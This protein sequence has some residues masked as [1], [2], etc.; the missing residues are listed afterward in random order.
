MV[1]FNDKVGSLHSTSTPETF[2]SSRSILRRTNQNISIAEQDL[3]VVP[4]YVESVRNASSTVKVLYRTKWMNGILVECEVS[5]VSILQGLSIVDSVAYVAPGS[6][7]TAGGRVRSSS[8]FREVTEGTAA[9]DV[10]L[11]MLGMDA[12]HEA[13]YRGEGMLIAIMD[14]GFP[15]ADTISFFKHVFDQNRFDAATSYD[16]VS[17]GSNVFRQNGHGTNVWSTI[18]A[19]KNGVFLGGAYKANYILF[20][21]EHAPTEYRV[22]EYNWLFAAE[23][24]DS[25]G[26]D[27]ITTSLGYTTFDDSSMNYSIADMDGQTTVIT[28]AA[29]IAASNGIAV[30]ASSGNEG[31]GSPTTIGAPAD[32]ENVLAVGSVTS[33]GIKSATSSIGPSADG[34]IK[35]DVAAMGSSVSVIW[36]NGLITS[37]SGTS[38]SAPLMASLVTGVWQALPELTDSQLLDTIRSVASQANNPDNQLGYGIPNFNQVVT[39]T[40]PEIAGYFVSIFPNPTLSQIKIEFIDNSQSDKLMIDLVDSKGAVSNVGVSSISNKEFLIDISNHQPGLYLLRLQLG[41]QFSVHKILKIE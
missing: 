34:R 3:P 30:V 7:P 20:I 26:V 12:M 32:G 4:A 29:E 6:R 18:A 10:Q 5:D 17:G 25:A 41:N 2:L 38:F 33:A 40:D 14:A 8:K 23:K 16:F 9:T 22:E 39:S 37:S 27:V 36:M 28:R 35:P 21:T 13:G 24:A 15:G 1:F 19:F 11:S 31:H